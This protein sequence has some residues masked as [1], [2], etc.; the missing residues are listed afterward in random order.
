MILYTVLFVVLVCSGVENNSRV[1][2]E[3]KECD[4][5][6]LGDICIKLNLSYLLHVTT[7]GTFSVLVLVKVWYQDVFQHSVSDE[8]HLIISPI[9]LVCMCKK[10][11]KQFYYSTA[12][13]HFQEQSV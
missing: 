10:G 6:T 3:S 12:D 13:Q 7:L 8:W 11:L 5:V 1:T 9:F 4:W 2:K